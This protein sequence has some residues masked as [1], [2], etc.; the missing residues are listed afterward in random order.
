MKSVG[1]VANV[2]QFYAACDVFAVPSLFE[3]LGLVAFE[4]AASGL[5]VIATEE[6]G[7]LS[8][9]LEYGAGVRWSAAE[10]L[11]PLIRNL[12]DNRGE[13]HEGARRMA[14]GLS[15]DVYRRRLLSV[16]ER[17]LN[18]GSVSWRAEPAAKAPV[19]PTL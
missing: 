13:F 11:S 19:L 8:A 5:P 3:P 16:Y 12:V 7:A 6:V 18:R 9:L 1:V 4:A 2:Q 15:R 17:V 14:E 10:K